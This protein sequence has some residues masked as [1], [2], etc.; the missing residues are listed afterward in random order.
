VGDTLARV[1]EPVSS[2]VPESLDAAAEAARYALLRRLAPAMRHH[3]VV[4]LQPIGMVYEIME[5]RMRAPQPNLA[6]IHE[7]AT[8]INSFARTALASCLDVITWIAPDKVTP[9]TAADGLAECLALVQTSFAFR[10]FSLRDE[11]GEVAGEVSRSAFRNVVT[12]SLVFLSDDHAP[13]AQLTVTGQ[14]MKDSLAITLTAGAGSGEEGFAT[15]PTYRPLVWS[16]VEAL[17][18]SESV[19]VQHDGA[20]IR[21]NLPWL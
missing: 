15:A 3:L 2:P 12:G 6:D 20:R 21:I 10:G 11:L 8:K 5:R 13:P 1:T 17:A 19:K 4:P 16:D 18:A 9:I 7:G 14:G